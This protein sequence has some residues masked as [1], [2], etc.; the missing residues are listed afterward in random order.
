LK[1]ANKTPVAD[2]DTEVVLEEVSLEMVHAVKSFAPFGIGNPGPLLL[3]K[4]L[5]V[6]EVKV[7]KEQHLKVLFTDGTR[8][9]SGFLWRQ[10]EH[11]ILQ[12]GKKVNLACRID[13]NVFNGN[14]T[15]QANIEAVEAA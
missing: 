14:T 12:A 8:Y 4:N 15:I 1:N 2:S 11:P 3:F 9:L 5:S 7:L 6:K 13:T 10:K